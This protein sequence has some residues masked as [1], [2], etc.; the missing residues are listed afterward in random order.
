MRQPLAGKRIAILATHGVEQI[1]LTEPRRALEEAGGSAELIGLDHEPIQGYD[2]AEKA[3]LLPVDRSIADVRADDYDALVLP[4]GV[5]NP[6]HLRRDDRAVGFVRD[7]FAAGKPIAAICHAAW[8]LVE[9]GVLPGRT[10]TSAPS[11]KTDIRNAGGNWVDETVVND[12]GLVSSRGPQD[13]DA[14]CTVM[15]KEIASGSREPRSIPD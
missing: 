5:R 9:A 11:L 1:E 4:G 10:I 7:M 12:E 13:L 15:V 3:D 14:F 8:T 6:D 2:H